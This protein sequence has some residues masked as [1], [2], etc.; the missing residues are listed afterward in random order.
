MSFARYVAL[1]DSST[2]GLDDPLQ[3]GSYRGW[4]DRV[5]DGLAHRNMNLQYANLAV[6]GRLAAEVEREQLPAALVLRPDLATVFAGVNDILRPSYD[7]VGTQASLTAM[8]G[9][10]RDVGAS[11]LTITAADLSAINPVARLVRPRLLDL[12][13]RIRAAAA[14]TGTYLVDVARMPEASD[15]RLWSE[16]RLHASSTGHERIAF[17]VLTVLGAQ[18]P[19]VSPLG[20]MPRLSPWHHLIWTAQHLGPWL[21]RRRRGVSSGTGRSCKHPQLSTWSPSA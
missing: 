17:E 16:D 5:A 1:G 11:V 10:L 7:P 20:P 6:R 3:D 13:D 19:A 4:A 18:P 14:A 21:G 12:N 8:F 15:R 9:A 2:E